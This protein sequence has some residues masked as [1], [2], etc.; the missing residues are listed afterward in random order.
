LALAYKGKQTTTNKWNIKMTKNFE[1]TYTSMSSAKRGAVR[2]GLV[3]PIFIK[4]DDGKILVTL[5]AKAKT[6]KA[7]LVSSSIVSPVAEF[8][9][10]FLANYGL[11]RRKDVIDL[12]VKQGVSRGTAAT[13]YQKLSSVT[14]TM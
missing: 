5:A 9:Q 8:R 13:Y 3:Q 6:K 4:R 10:I 7:S 2:A 14:R 11:L 12:A 1:K